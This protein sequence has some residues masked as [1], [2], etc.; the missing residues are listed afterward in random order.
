MTAA[1]CRHRYEIRLGINTGLHIQCGEC[2]Q[3]FA[4]KRR[5][6]VVFVDIPLV[7]ACVAA[8]LAVRAQG[9]TP[10]AWL[11]MPLVVGGAAW[12]TLQA[13]W[14]AVCL[15]ARRMSRLDRLLR[16]AK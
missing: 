4:L 14:Y 5:F 13:L 3:V 9:G 11:G 1:V 15:V 12:E 8:M 7:C 16:E 2:G 6:N 10:I